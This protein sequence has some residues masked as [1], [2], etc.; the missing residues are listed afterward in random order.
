MLLASNGQCMHKR[1]SIQTIATLISMVNQFLEIL[2]K[3][4]RAVRMR[5]E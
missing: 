3:R 1:S 5:A 4:T 2:E